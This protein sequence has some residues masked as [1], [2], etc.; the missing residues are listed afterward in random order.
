[1]ELGITQ[2]I[3]LLDYLGLAEMSNTE[4]VQGE[5]TYVVGA[6]AWRFRSSVLSLLFGGIWLQ[7][8]LAFCSGS[9]LAESLLALQGLFIL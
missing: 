1:M 6:D 2:G 3:P 7:G 5:S 8:L 4:L 9:L